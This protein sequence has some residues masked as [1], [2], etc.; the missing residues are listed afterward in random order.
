M[1]NTRTQYSNHTYATRFD[2][3][4]TKINLQYGKDGETAFI[5]ILNE[6]FGDIYKWYSYNDKYEAVDFYGIKH[7]EI[8]E[9]TIYTHQELEHKADIIIELKSKRSI[10]NRHTQKYHK[11][12]KT[13]GSNNNSLYHFVNWTKFIHIR[14]NLKNGNI[15]RAFIVFDYMKKKIDN[16]LS[17]YDTNNSGVYYF[18]EITLDKLEFDEQLALKLPIKSREDKFRT[19]FLGFTYSQGD[20]YNS[21][22]TV[23][24][25]VVQI[26]S[27]NL[28]PMKYFKSTLSYTQKNKSID[29]LIKKLGENIELEDYLFNDDNSIVNKYSQE[30][31][32]A[33][34]TAK[35]FDLTL[36]EYI[37]Q[38]ISKH[39]KDLYEN[40]KDWIYL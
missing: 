23:K 12:L 4:E 22:R 2:E 24:D 34:Y 5:K 20:G 36:E 11:A 6:K 13:Q 15:K 14:N 31:R 18:H 38:K 28:L 17:N 37:D 30:K 25:K 39:Y 9:D 8:N 7:S 10:V 16:P 40:S 3:D 19:Q 26:T 32:S 21:Y 29:R 27:T 33:K 35:I 1:N